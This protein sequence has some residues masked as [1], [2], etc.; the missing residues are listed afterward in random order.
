MFKDL[1]ENKKINGASQDKNFDEFDFDSHLSQPQPKT[2]DKTIETSK[3]FGLQI[4]HALGKFLY[5][6]R[7]DKSTKEGKRMTAE[8]LLNIPK[9][10]FY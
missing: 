2:N 4:F 5:N 1:N 7:I 3:D 10:K 9:P 6:K 8:Q